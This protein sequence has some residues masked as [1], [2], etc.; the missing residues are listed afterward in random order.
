LELTLDHFGRVLEDWVLV[1]YGRLNLRW[2]SYIDETWTIKGGF[3]PMNDPN[4]ERLKLVPTWILPPY[5]GR[6]PL[7]LWQRYIFYPLPDNCFSFSPSSPPDGGLFLCLLHFDKVSASDADPLVDILDM[8]FVYDDI[9]NGAT[10]VTYA[11]ASWGINNNVDSSGYP[12][13]GPMAG[14]W[15]GRP[16]TGPLDAGQTTWTATGVS[17]LNLDFGPQPPITQPGY[18]VFI[19]PDQIVF[20]NFIEEKGEIV[21]GDVLQI[22]G[23]WWPRAVVLLPELILF[24]PPPGIN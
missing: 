20:H 5:I 9:K 21:P 18:N 24:W 14:I 11:A 4:T 8:V 16:F 19:G 2:V 17:A 10:G 22:T 15:E 13:P 1:G 12:A 23:S 6:E 3:E 7:P